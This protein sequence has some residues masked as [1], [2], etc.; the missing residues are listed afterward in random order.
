M[1]V[2]L[3]FQQEEEEA[4]KLG[5][6]AKHKVTPSA[7]MMECLQVEEEQYVSCFFDAFGRV[8]SAMGILGGKYASK[9]S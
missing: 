9:R 1:Q 2:R 5:L 3:Q 6:P 4:A 8:L 7:F